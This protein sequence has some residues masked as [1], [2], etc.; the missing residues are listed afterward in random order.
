VSESA[1]AGRRTIEF[2]ASDG[3]RLVGD[4]AVPAEPRG[5]AIICHPHPLYG[6]NRFNNVVAALFDALPGAGVAAL[7]FDFRSA[8]SGGEAERLDALAALDEIATVVP[9]APLIAVGYSFGALIA[10]GLGDDRLD[11]LVLVAAPLAMAST[12]AAP[13]VPTLLLTPAH[14]QFSPPSASGPI[15]ATW[16]AAPVDHEV[17]ET[18]DHSL[19][20]HTAVV[21]DAVVT[22]ISDRV[23]S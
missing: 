17:V 14:D 6:G 7:R 12:V 10:L 23:S 13:T 3:V 16:T 2:T 18:A 9:G 15:V 11:A 22:W 20:G 8:F 4:L 21:A 19:V 1:S 5:A